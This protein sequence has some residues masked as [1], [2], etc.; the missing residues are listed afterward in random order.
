MDMFSN[1]QGAL[2]T[3]SLRTEAIRRGFFFTRMK[4]VLRLFNYSLIKGE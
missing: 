3:L 1:F 4:L 2:A